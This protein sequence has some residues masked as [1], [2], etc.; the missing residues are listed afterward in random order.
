MNNQNLVQPELK[1]IEE[2]KKEIESLKEELVK[3]KAQAED[4]LNGWKRAKADYINFKRETERRQKEI[5]EFANAALLLEI[6]PLVDQF[7]QAFKHLSKDLEK[8]DWVVGIRHIQA[9]LKKLLSDL[10]ITE[11]PTIGEKF[12]PELYEA[13]GEVESDLEKGTV[14]EEIKTG[15]KINNKVI[16]PAKVKIA[17][18]ITKKNPEP[19]KGLRQEGGEEK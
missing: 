8:S 16:Q 15:F 1:K 4:H 3:A 14:V 13:I 10:G 9:N 2:L 12:N 18:E 11:V 19:L 7:K 17:K 6:F 5:I